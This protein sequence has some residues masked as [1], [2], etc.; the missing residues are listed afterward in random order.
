MFEGEYLYGKVISFSEVNLEMCLS[1]NAGESLLTV[2]F[3][4]EEGTKF[5]FLVEISLRDE[6]LLLDVMK[7]S[8]LN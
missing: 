8:N 1:S 3:W 4:I 2:S 7:S 5:R 6:R